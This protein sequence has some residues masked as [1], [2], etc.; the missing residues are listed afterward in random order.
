MIHR[1]T[2]EYAGCTEK[3]FLRFMHSKTIKVN[4]SQADRAPLEMYN[5]N[6]Q[7]KPGNTC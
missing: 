7:C 2:S 6:D 4:S 1:D 5:E 3:Q